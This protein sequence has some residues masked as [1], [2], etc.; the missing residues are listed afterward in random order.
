MSIRPIGPLVLLL[1]ASALAQHAELTPRPGLPASL[2]DVAFMAGHWVGGEKGDLSEEVWTSPDGD[3]MLGMWR[4]VSQGQ[5][6]IFL[7]LTYRSE[8]QGL[9]SVLEKQGS[10]QE[11]RFRAR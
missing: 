8:G 10:K 5:V 2:K 11:F 6:R 4:Y 3:S 7:R 9:V 1:A